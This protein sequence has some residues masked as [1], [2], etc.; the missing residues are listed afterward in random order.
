MRVETKIQRVREL[1]EKFGKKLRKY[2]NVTGLGVGYKE[3]RGKRTAT[4]ALRIYVEKKV[5]KKELRAKDVLPTMI[6]GMP[7]DVIEK[8]F[9]IH[10]AT[11]VSEHR[12]FHN[13]LIGGIS[14]GNLIAGGSGTLGMLVYDRS[15]AP[16]ILSNW[17]VL[18]SSIACASG[19][20]IIQPGTSGGDLGNADG[21][22][23]RLHRWALTSRV[24]AAVAS[25]TGHR[26]AA[27]ELLGIGTLSMY[28]SVSLG[29]TVW[30]S[31]RTTGVT[32]GQVDDVNADVDIDFR[33]IL[34]E[35][36]AFVNQIVVTGTP[37]FDRGDSG[38]VL[39]D[40]SN[41]VIGL[42]FAGDGNSAVANEIS[43]VIQALDIY[44]TGNSFL[45]FT[46]YASS[47][48]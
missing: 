26:F 24:D 14:I 38:S 48:A 6:E 20:P 23:A 16:L 11:S 37:I 39:V 45:D 40:G 35:T 13:L 9:R 12:R 30:K 41:K 46:A 18:C 32:R 3:K 42:N 27:Q 21:L 5:P 2:P 22:I 29:M 7:L 36:R 34:N 44:L 43:D 1:K 4:I 15:G 19:E 8:K 31:G 17:H 33:P 28:G 25:L 10:Q 47:S